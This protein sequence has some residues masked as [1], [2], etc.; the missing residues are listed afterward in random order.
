M[1]GFLVF[2]LLTAACSTSS[3]EELGCDRVANHV[4]TVRAHERV[5]RVPERD[6][7]AHARALITAA[8]P[9]LRAA[10]EQ[11]PATTRACLQQA[12]STSALDACA[13]GR[14]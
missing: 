8:T 4:A 7:G 1:R 9:A 3:P 2:G 6:R 5:A 13:E 10:C 14:P 12:M 11:A